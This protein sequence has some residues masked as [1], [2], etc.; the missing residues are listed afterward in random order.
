MQLAGVTGEGVKIYN[1]SAG[2]SLP[3]W[4]AEKKKAALRYGLP[5]ISSNLPIFF[6]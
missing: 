3:E 4:L 6:D 1:V 2:K 5:F